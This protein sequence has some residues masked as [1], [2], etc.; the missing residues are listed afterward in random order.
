M[1]DRHS[2]QMSRPAGRRLLVAALLAALF[3]CAATGCSDTEADPNTHAT[4]VT[5]RHQLIGGLNALGD[6]GD[7]KLENDEIQLIVQ[8]KGYNRG[9][10][11]FGGSLIDADLQR[12]NQDGGLTDGGNG[13]DTFAELFPAYFLEVVDPEQVEVVNDGSDGEAAI[14][15]VS[16]N[17][18]EFVTMLRYINQVMVNS[19]ET[20]GIDD[21]APSD[22]EDW[23]P[24]SSENPLVSFRTRYIL[25]PGARHVRIESTIENNSFQTL[26][27]PNQEI[28][29]ALS[30]ALGLD[31]GD[32]S[33]PAGNVLGFGAANNLFVP[34]IGYDIR[35][36]LEDAYRQGAQL[37]AFP[38]KLT[39]FIASSNGSAE[40]SYAY[41][42]EVAPEE[43]FAYR[44][45]QGPEQ[46]YNGEAEPGDALLLF[47]S[48]GFGGAFTHELPARLSSSYCDPENP[49]QSAEA[50]CDERLG[51]CNGDET[52]EAN[53]SDCIA[54]YDACLEDSQSHPSSYTFTNYFVVGDGSISS[55]L[56]EMYEVRG[57]ETYEV[58]GRV[59]DD[60]S[61]SPVG[62]N[63]ELLVYRP[64]KRDDENELPANA[65]KRCSVEG[66]GAD[67]TTP[68]VFNQTFTNEAGYFELTLPPGQ[69][70]YRTHKSGRPLGDYHYFRVRQEDRALR[71]TADSNA[72]IDVRIT[73]E[74]GQPMPAKVTVVGTHEYRGETAKRHYL[75]DLVSGEPWRTTD[76]EPDQ[77][78]DPSTRKYVEATG[79][80][81]ADGEANLELRPGSYTVYFSRGPEYELVTR[82]VDLSA[83]ETF[84]TNVSLEQVVDTG[85][86]VSGD[87]HMH[88][89]GSIDSGLNYTD[90]VVS[91]AA[92]D[93]DVVV[94]SDHNYVSDYLPYI[95]REGL[96]DWLN[97]VVGVELTTFEFGHFNAFPLEYEGGSINR[98]SIKWQQIPPQQIFDELRSRGSLGEDE[99]IIQVN[100]PRDSILGYF[101][102]FN[103]DGFRAEGGLA[104]N[105]I[106]EDLGPFEK[107]ERQATVTAT[108]SSGEAFVRDCRS[109]EVDCRPDECPDPPCEE[110]RFETQLSWDFDALEIFNGKRMELMRHYR[111]PYEKGGWPEDTLMGV[112]EQACLENND[113]ETKC[114]EP[115]EIK[116]RYVRDRCCEQ[117]YQSPVDGFPCDDPDQGACPV[118]ELI[119]EVAAN[120][121]PKGHVVCDGDEV[122]YAGGLDD[123]YNMLNHPRRFVRNEPGATARD[124]EIYHK[125][126]ATGNSDSHHAGK[127]NLRDP[128]HPRNYFHAGTDDP[129]QVSDRDL[130]DA[131]QNQR[132]IVTNGPFTKLEVRRGER[133][134]E[135]GQQMV[136]GGDQLTL[137]ATVRAADWVGADR[138]RIIANGEPLDLSQWN[139]INTYDGSQSNPPHPTADTGEHWFEVNL[140]DNGQWQGKFDVEVDRDTWFVLEVAGDN[141]LFPVYKPSEI[142]RIPFDDIIGQ[143]AGS[144]GFGGGVEGLAP[145]ETFPTRPFAFTNPIWIVRT[146]GS[147]GGTFDPPGTE[148]DTTTACEGSAF[149]PTALQSSGATGN[150]DEPSRLDATSAPLNLRNRMKAPLAIPQGER[151]DVRSFFQAWGH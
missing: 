135:I 150:I 99:T 104:I 112:A 149:D 28:L 15:E 119:Q 121:Y 26:Q 24:P 148:A 29:S 117:G 2:D 72:H 105:D 77:P 32:F 151:R 37:P 18:G 41:F 8:D 137:R 120:N 96:Q 50:Y 94:S 11:L 141:N 47:Y 134:A 61:G 56:D 16:G 12:T 42:P 74:G 103:V 140:G 131:L 1:T 70:C 10:G 46:L 130:V 44:K 118:D 19:Y 142:P 27:F 13:R 71:A 124:D 3:G 51:E 139:D 25:E 136:V 114:E 59:Y 38:G 125:V 33:V 66:S 122:G 133:E 97:S 144:F 60:Q 55:V 34:G 9:S 14:V 48:S 57:R 17:G 108:M 111:V 52:C 98:G 35:W 45:D 100:H 89:Q 109:D 21:L 36:G 69:Y 81:S 83:G 84:R 23:E 65:E 80:S 22:I 93:V 79:Y 138:F 91:I 92:E 143:I 6:I 43:N 82:E 102:Q 30:S 67:K 123:W 4:Q 106:P 75:F 20:G 64:W 5:S 63:I 85:D 110:P 128:G 78:D 132:N 86:W 58:Q 53:K 62:E 7:Y 129:Q 146:D 39:P 87:F 54:G 127:P 107:R 49:D 90:R 126:T 147:G 73:S 76:H 113:D 95:R 31:L 115:G 101:S 68:V 116:A 88:A 40:V 145:D